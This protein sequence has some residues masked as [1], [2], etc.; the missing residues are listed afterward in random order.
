LKSFIVDAP[1]NRIFVLD[2]IAFQLTLCLTRP[3][4][5]VFAREKKRERGRERRERVSEE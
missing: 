4:L 3:C 5:R 2:K 1:E